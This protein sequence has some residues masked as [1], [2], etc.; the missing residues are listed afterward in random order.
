MDK[1]VRE[2]HNGQSTEGSSLALE[3]LC[4]VFDDGADAGFEEWLVFDKSGFLH[5]SR[6][7]GAFI[8]GRIDAAKPAPSTEGLRE[9]I[10]GLLDGTYDCL[11]GQVTGWAFSVGQLRELHAL[12]TTQ[13]DRELVDIMP[14]VGHLPEEAQDEIRQFQDWLRGPRIQPFKWEKPCSPSAPQPESPRYIDPDGLV[15]SATG[16]ASTVD[17]LATQRT[18][19]ETFVER[20]IRETDELE[21]ITRPQGEPFEEN[22]EPTTNAGNISDDHERGQTAEGETNKCAEGSP[23]WCPVHGDCSCHV[24]NGEG[25]RLHGDGAECDAPTREE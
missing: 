18:E 1:F 21:A 14:Y 3:I 6:A 4:R 11:D 7:L 19:P 20:I 10:V 9:H 8:R 17:D 16:G 22:P 15:E 13:V 24:T 12:L 23:T 2:Q 5:W 25:C